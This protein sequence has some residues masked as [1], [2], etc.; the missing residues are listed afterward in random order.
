MLLSQKSTYV[1]RLRH[2]YKIAYHGFMVEF[3]DY[4]NTQELEGWYN[5]PVRASK[6]IKSIRAIN[7]VIS[8]FR[9]H[10]LKRTLIISY[11]LLGTMVWTATTAYFS[12]ERVT[13]TETQLRATQ[14]FGNGLGSITATSM[15][16]SPSNGMVVMELTTSDATSAINKGINTENLDWQVF[17]PSSVKNPEAVTLE[18]IPLTG[19]KVYLVLRNVPSD[20]TLM[21]IRVTNKTPNSNSLKVDVQEYDDYLSSS[22]NSVSNQKKQKDKDANKTYVDFFVTPQ[23]ELLKNKYVKNLSREKFALNIFEEELKY[24]KGQRK[25]LLA[26][27]KTLDDSIKEDNKTLEQLKRESEYLVGN[28][29]TDKQ[30]DMESVEKSIGTKEK[31]GAKARENAAY[32]QT[33]IEQI[34]KNIKAVKDGT[35]KFNS[36]VRSVKQDIDE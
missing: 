29:L 26:S 25:E 13:Y 17:L 33:I 5:W 31:D 11:A 23:N 28:E 24:Q 14:T 27:A 12:P 15:T 6:K 8:Y 32:V 2:L 20:Y 16:Y 19:D 18:V 4:E 22:S 3:K 36:P 30:I 35:Y 34:E 1:T 7:S 21:V 9:K 10:R